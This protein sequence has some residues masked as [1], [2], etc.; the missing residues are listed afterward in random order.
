MATMGNTHDA[1][2][3]GSGERAAELPARPVAAVPRGSVMTAV[4]ILGLTQL[5]LVV[6]V[7]IVNVALPEIGTAL[8]FSDTSLSWVVTAYALSFGGLILLSGK[9]GSLIGPRRALLFGVSVFVLASVAGGSAPTAAVLVAAR[10]LQG[11]GAALAAPSV[12]VLMM[13][14]TTPG[15]QRSRAMSLFVLATGSGAALGLLTGGV[16]TQT[17]G[18]EWVMYV[19]APIGAV[20]V[21]G[22]LRHL[23]ELP[24]QG[25]ALDI[26]GAVAST[27]VMV[28][29]VVA[30]TGAAE[31]GWPSPVVVAAFAV[32]VLAGCALVLVERRH[33]H[34]VLPPELFTSMRSAGPL[35]SMLAIPAGQVGFLYF[36]TLLTQHVLGFSPLQTGLALVPFTA[37]LIVTNQLT[38]RLLPRLGERVIGVAGLTGLVLGI[39]WMS[40]VAADA[41]S[42]SSLVPVLLPSVLLGAGAGATFA[43]VT[44][45]VMH[46]APAEH[47]GAAASLIQGLQQ[48]GGGMGLA[49]LTSVL[50]G[51]G[52]LAGGLPTTFLTAA[53]FPLTALVLFGTWAR[54]I[55]TRAAPGGEHVT[56]HDTV[57]RARRN[58]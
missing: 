5:M 45:V 35:L 20:V 50:A 10:A 43:P 44:A 21:A 14:V 37:G 23:P 41:G 15:P 53:A 58:R 29:L 3:G 52:G 25:V 6:D 49:V 39:A 51:T 7:S 13:G 16:L 54:R 47:V 46:Q 31:R 56:T 24:R 33:P 26:T 27:L 12:M 22:A 9:V 38:P 17:L 55:P 1:P 36:T 40:L 2:M 42:H 11:V 30:F 34:P 18:W 32:A 4:T 57:L 48:L 8:G 28:A 19:N